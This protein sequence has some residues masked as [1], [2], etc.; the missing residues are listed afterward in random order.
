MLLKDRISIVTGGSSGVGRGIALEF[1]R[2]G[3][4]VAIADKQEAPLRGKYHV[5][6]V[7]TPTVK[8]IKKLG[9][10]AIFVQTDVTEESQIERL[11]ER[12]VQHFGGLDI[13][14]NNAGIHIPGGAQDISIAEWD[15]VVGTNLRGVFVATK[16]AISHLTQF[17]VW[18]NHPDRLRP[19]L[20]RRRGTRLCPSES[21][22]RQHGTRYHHRGR[23]FRHNRQRH[24]SR[25]HRD[26]APRLPHAGDD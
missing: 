8:E 16:L 20:R 13:L 9:G 3:A 15:K 6:D 11:I 24:L 7:T 23:R 5:T 21:R 19:R 17:Q 22:R 14:V 1:A 25:L 18:T 12:T 2:E 26:G 10:Q 4:S